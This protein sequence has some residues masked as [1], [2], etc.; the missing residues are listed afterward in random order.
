M[1]ERELLRLMRHA[2][3][4]HLSPELPAEILEAL[5][6]DTR[7]EAAV[8]LSAGDDPPVVW[9]ADCNLEGTALGPPW[10]PVD[11]GRDDARWTVFL[12]GGRPPST[13][14][15]AVVAMALHMLE[16]R[17]ELRRS[18]FDERSRL[19]ELEAVRAIAESVGGILEPSRIA[20]E[21]I[22]HLLGLLGVRRA[23]I[24][25][26]TEPEEAST[27][28]AFGAPVLQLPVDPAVW[29]AGRRED[30]VLA[31]PL[32]VRG[33]HLG[34]L[35]VADKE[36]RTGTEPFTDGDARVVELFAAQVAVALENARLSRESIEQARLR[37]EM[38][39]AAA[40]QAHLYPE[41]F[42]E[43]AGWRVR[44]RYFPMREV[45]G[46]SFDVVQRDGG[47][48]AAVTDVSGK[49]VSAGMLAAGLHALTR[50]LAE[51]GVT[52]IALAERLNSYLAGVTA[53]NRFATMVAVELG[54]DGSFRAVHAGHCPSLIRRAD[55]RVEELPSNG[56]PL[57][58][59]P[60]ARY[61]DTGGILAPGELLILY[62]DGITEAENAS[63]RE[64]GVERFKEM[65]AGI[66]GAGADAACATILDAVASFSDG[67]PTDDVTLVVVE[68]EAGAEPLPG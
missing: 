18:R 8:L 56:L 52:V 13:E 58:I 63:G 68:R 5:A 65:V 66:G 53:D 22:A 7:A 21:V 31:A 48:L 45:A 28:A 41:S 20:E 44:A 33:R 67:S 37:H 64:L 40:V 25:L 29:A 14:L 15:T 50:M 10:R 19:W 3:R 30:D 62:T 60:Q 57:G 36:A 2:L 54:G 9:P 27:V 16:M 32:T 39:L 12:H 17:E 43:V 26:G 24:V 49:G 46:D 23:Q 6:V 35:A 59:L 34:I 1:G 47:L 55:G 42:P 61:T 11:L 4:E 51:E 38:D